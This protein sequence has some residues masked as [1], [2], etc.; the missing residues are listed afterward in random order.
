MG[1]FKNED[2]ENVFHGKPVRRL[3]PGILRRARMRLQRVV[4]ATKLSDLRLPPSHRLE[5]LHGSREGQHSIRIND[6]WRVCFRWTEQGAME[7]EITDDHWGSDSD[8][9]SSSTV[10]PGKPR[11]P[12][13]TGEEVTTKADARSTTPIPSAIPAKPES[14][15]RIAT[16][17]RSDGREGREIPPAPACPGAW[18]VLRNTFTKIHSSGVI[19]T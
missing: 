7:I 1:Q 17:R 5:A 15:R 11:P 8:R 3:P 19:P 9:S 4:A 18:R 14:V 2:T 10:L 16:I 6:Q 13:R 12:L